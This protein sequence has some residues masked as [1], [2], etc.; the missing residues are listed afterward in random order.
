MHPTLFLIE[1]ICPRGAFRHLLGYEAVNR[2][3]G[4]RVQAST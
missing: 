1:Y 3:Q 4:E 2:C